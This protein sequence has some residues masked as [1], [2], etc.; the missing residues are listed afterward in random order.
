MDEQRNSQD[1]FIEAEAGS[2]IR[3][4]NP[5]SLGFLGVLVKIASVFLALFALWFNSFGVMSELHQNAIFFAVIGFIGF[6]LYPLSRK[7]AKE[8]L[9]IDTILAF[10]VLISGL[11]IVFFENTIHAR[12]EVL[13]TRDIIFGTIA[14]VLLI[15]LSRRAA[16][17]VI[18]FLAILFSA[19]AL[20]L[21]R[22][23]PPGMFSFRGIYF[24]TYI[25]RMY[26]TNDG[27]FGYIATIATTYVYLFILFAAFF[28][29][30]GAGDFIIDIAKATLGKTTGG[31]AKVA[32]LASGLMGSITGSSVANVVGTGSITIPLMKKIGFKS[33]FAGGVETAA[34]VGGQMMPPIMGAGAFIMAQWTQIPYTTIIG[35][36][37]IPAVMY[38]LGVLLNVHIRAKKSNLRP[39]DESEIPSVRD[40]LRRGW[41]FLIPIAVLVGL[42]VSGYTP[43]YAAIISIVAVVVSSWIRKETRMGPKKIINAMI[44]G[45]RNMVSTGILLLI[46]GI[47]VGVITLTGLGISLSIIVTSLTKNSIFLLFIFTALAALFLGMGLP[48]TASYIVLAILIAP[49]FKMLGVGILAANMVVFWL[50]E[51]AN[52]T[53]PIALAAFAASGIAGSDPVKTA[54]EGFKLAKGLLLIPI[55]FLYTKLLAGLNIEVVVPAISGLF[56]LFGFTIFLEGYWTKPLNVFER[57][58]FLMAGLLSY[59]PSYETDALGVFLMLFLFV[60]YWF[61]EK[62]LSTA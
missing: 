61:R 5:D 31:P 34:S 47:I 20:F 48:V 56:G 32:V 27:I 60:Y 58:A 50:A 12:N 52:V 2:N 25:Y 36:A 19:Y 6:I 46:A 35:K 28:L 10:L 14:V 16:G 45:T 29:E 24:S 57:V 11:Y 23:M 9:K 39:L 43:T 18:P 55:L 7:K 17:Y 30:S 54:I 15:E 13:I 62:K 22:L 37:F 40:V 33:E 51:T 53:P 4:R 1:E 44:A 21:G 49:A 26:F 41:H 8:T 38:Y 59:Y 42:L 3:L